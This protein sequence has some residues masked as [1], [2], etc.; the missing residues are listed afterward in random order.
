[1]ISLLS[2]DTFSDSCRRSRRWSN[3]SLRRRLLVDMFPLLAIGA[4]GVANLVGAVGA[5]QGA[6]RAEELG[7]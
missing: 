2:L 1:M 5:L 6:R 4:V 3:F 7:A